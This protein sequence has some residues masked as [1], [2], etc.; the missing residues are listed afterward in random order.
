MCPMDQA[1]FWASIRLAARGSSKGATATPGKQGRQAQVGDGLTGEVA[2]VVSHQH[3][4]AGDALHLEG[5]GCSDAS[6][7]DQFNVFH[8]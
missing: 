4:E 8:G 6:P 7:L 5:Q 3:G 1:R 2:P